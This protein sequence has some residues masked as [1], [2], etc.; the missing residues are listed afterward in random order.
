MPA[1]INAY[2]GLEKVFGD[3]KTTLDA[4]NEA[5]NNQNGG[6]SVTDGTGDNADDLCPEGWT[7]EEWDQ[8]DCYHA[9]HY[10]AAGC[11]VFGVLLLLC[12]FCYCCSKCCCKKKENK[13]EVQQYVNTVEMAPA[14]PQVVAIDDGD[15]TANAGDGVSYVGNSQQSILPQQQ[16]NSEIHN[17]Q[18]FI[19]ISAAHDG[20][21]PVK[22]KKKKK[23]RL[24]QE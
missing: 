6:G 19:N 23:K 18:S 20:G 11:S 9:F 22:E 8:L 3:Y 24:Q 4:L 13:T 7:M 5:N 1:K 10:T 15:Q 17:L 21:V 16:K 14:H 2:E 12:C